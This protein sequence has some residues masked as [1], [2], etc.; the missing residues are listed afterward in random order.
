MMGGNKANASIF[1]D[2]FEDGDLNLGTQWYLGG[3]GTGNS[4]ANVV[5][6][7]S[8]EGHLRQVGAS[9]PGVGTAVWG[10]VSVSHTFDYTPGLHFDF[11]MAASAVTA[12]NANARAG[13]E[14]QFLNVLG[15]QID[16]IGMMYA[17]YSLP[18]KYVAIADTAHHLY[19]FT[20]EDLMSAAGMTSSQTSQVRSIFMKFEAAS[21]R[22]T[23]AGPSYDAS[24]DVWFD[25]VN[26]VPE[27]ATMALLGLGGLLTLRR[28]RKV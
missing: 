8:K 7:N 18:S 4:T 9:T 27:P 14:F 21:Q 13:V 12:F 25:N 16:S 22:Y 3:T 17:T 5:D 24:S 15:T 10:D 20:A 19:S 6:L 26:V 11:I 2:D 1:Y 28:K 23:H